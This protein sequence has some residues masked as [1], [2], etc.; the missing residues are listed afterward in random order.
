MFVALYIITVIVLV[1]VI[2]FQQAS[3]NFYHASYKEADAGWKRCLDS[4]YECLYYVFIYSATMERYEIKDFHPDDI[5]KA[6]EL[7]S[8]KLYSEYQQDQDKE[9]VSDSVE[10]QDTTPV[11]HSSTETAHVT[12]PVI[13][14]LD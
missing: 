7:C 10:S 14:N 9:R 3:I 4:V 1:T 5:K 2:C 13:A 8:K 6:K 12:D 11:E